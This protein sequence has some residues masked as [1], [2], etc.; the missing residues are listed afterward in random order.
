MEAGAIASALTSNRG[1]NIT[2]RQPAAN[3]QIIYGQQ[4]V[5]G[6]MVY[7]STTGSKKDQLNYVIVIAGHQCHSIQ[8]L[9]LDGRQVHWNV[10]SGGNS[11]RNGVNFGG[12]ADGNTYTGP[13]G[14]QYNLLVASSTPRRGTAIRSMV[15]SSVASPPTIHGLG[16][17]R[18][19]SS[20]WLGGCTYIYLKVEN[21]P[22][23]F[24]SEPEIR[25]TVNGKDNIWDPRTQ[26]NGFSTNWALIAADMITDNVFGLGDNSV[27]QDQLIA[28]ANVCDEQID[29]ASGLTE[30]RYSCSTHYDTSTA[31]GDALASIMNNC[32]G[33]LSNIGGQWYVWPD[34]YQG[35]SYSFG[36][37]H[38]TAPFQWKPYRSVPELVNCVT[39][40]YTAPTYP[41]NVAGESV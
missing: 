33:G 9:Y 15:T 31:P 21:N 32:K 5:G 35:P 28:A 22:T 6:V 40:I 17:Q 38:L 1:M 2:T 16:G 24:P 39:G 10:G 27:N 36:E 3:R 26:T 11:T 23:V 12:S 20:P 41:Y 37:Q 4:R 19:R 14:L 18:G 13:N 7:K 29:L 30:S 34:Y 8:N 25:I